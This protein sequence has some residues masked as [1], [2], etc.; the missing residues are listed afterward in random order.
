MNPETSAASCSHSPGWASHWR[1]PWCRLRVV[2]TYA[3]RQ[4]KCRWIGDGREALNDL[5]DSVG[6]YKNHLFTLVYYTNKSNS[7]YICMF[8]LMQIKVYRLNWVS[9]EHPCCSS[10]TGKT[11]DGPVRSGS[12]GLWSLLCPPGQHSANQEAAWQETGH[13]TEPAPGVLI[14]NF[15]SGQQE[16]CLSHLIMV[17]HHGSQLD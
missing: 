16:S 7:V 9:P 3:G 6:G 14:H 13:A 8:F 11:G 17:F 2:V 1:Q 10:N 5:I 12:S 15:A 4:L